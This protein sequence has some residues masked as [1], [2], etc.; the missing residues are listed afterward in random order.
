MR[1]VSNVQCSLRA[2]ASL[3]TLPLEHKRLAE[4]AAR[5][6]D[7]VKT[8]ESR[9]PLG[10]RSLVSGLAWTATLGVALSGAAKAQG[11]AGV[12]ATGG[13]VSRTFQNWFQYPYNTLGF[14]AIGNGSSNPAS[15]VYGS[16]AAL[17][18]VYGVTVSGIP[19][20]LTM[21]LD[22]L[23][24]QAAINAA[25]SA[26]GTVYSP[27]RVY[28]VS[29]ANS[30]SDGSGQLVFPSVNPGNT[31]QFAVNW[32]GD[33]QSTILKWPFAITGGQSAVLC[34]GRA[35][36]S[37]AGF[38]EDLFLVGPGTGVTLGASSTTMHGIATNDRRNIFRCQIN[39]FWAGIDLVGGQCHHA[40]VIC[41]S[42][43]Y[44]YYF[45]SPNSGNFGNMVF[46]R[47][48][49][50]SCNQAGVG[51]HHAAAVINSVFTGCFF[52]TN[53]YSFFKET[54]SGSPTQAQI[55]FGCIFDLTQFE[56]FGN[57]CFCDDTST[58]AGRVATLY[59]CIFRNCQY[60]WSSTFKIPAVAAFSV[61][62]VGHFLHNVIDQISQPEQLTPGSNGIFYANDAG[63][64]KMT[65]FIGQVISN[66][67]SN[68]MFTGNGWFNSTD[69]T[70]ENIDY[71]AW[72]GE[73]AFSNNSLTA[74]QFVTQVA[75]ASYN[76]LQ[77]SAGNTSDAK[78][79]VLMFLP[80][81]GQFAIIAVSGAVT[82]KSSGTV[83]VGQILRTAAAGAVVA[84]SGTNDTTSPIV[85]V[86]TGASGGGFCVI[87][88]QAL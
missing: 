9:L 36:A 61:F 3:P 23:A 47:V 67:G 33:F 81:T 44:G 73:L 74:G 46:E 11:I 68:P 78:L 56:N 30:A 80:G 62:D 52:G 66:C 45:N 4:K 14:G 18:A 10:R 19:V 5:R 84:A 38:F 6:I 75:S 48:L 86:A 37:S 83:T 55:A 15:S 17:Q 24:H 50:G 12:P 29:N 35:S 43:Y 88:L 57:A 63:G 41:T 39:G 76:I 64:F 40:D 16:L 49:A 85:G 53:P 79:G 25:T 51:V 77:A 58:Q 7:F 69:I 22:W 65:G 71:A 13:L 59:G 27:G 32:K 72:K 1:I 87:K 70:F 54:N 60:S 8:E 26:G 28:V 34:L 82:A 31:A 2:R 21:E 20:A 42:N